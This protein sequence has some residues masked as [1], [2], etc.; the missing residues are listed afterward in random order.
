[1]AFVKKEVQVHWS[2]IIRF[3]RRF[4]PK[5][6]TLYCIK[7]NGKYFRS[8]CITN[9]FWTPRS[10][11]HKSGGVEARKWCSGKMVGFI[12][13]QPMG[14][15]NAEIKIQLE[16]C[17]EITTQINFKNPPCGSKVRCLNISP[18]Y[19]SPAPHSQGFRFYQKA[20]S[21]TYL[22]DKNK[23]W[24]LTFSAPRNFESLRWSCFVLS[25]SR[26]NFLNKTRI[27][28]KFIQNAPKFYCLK[29]RSERSDSTS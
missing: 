25:N 28:P 6:L 14:N 24:N 10:I 29:S 7:F 26:K 22:N 5:A 11:V 20:L 18:T 23:I 19:I 3:E 16:L 13:K 17:I 4:L 8:E 2:V 9:S 12:Y 27:S 21:A 15:A 1:M